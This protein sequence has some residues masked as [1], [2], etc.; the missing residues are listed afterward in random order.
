[1]LR[2]R[3]AKGK[4]ARAGCRAHGDYPVSKSRNGS[5]WMHKSRRD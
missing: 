4:L 1:V 5:S 2:R 3:R